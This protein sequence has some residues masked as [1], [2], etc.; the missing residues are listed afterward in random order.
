MSHPANRTVN[1]TAQTSADLLLYPAATGSN[2]PVSMKAGETV[3]SA[4]AT[5]DVAITDPVFVSVTPSGSSVAIPL[6]SSEWYFSGTSL[7]LKRPLAYNATVAWGSAAVHPT[8]TVP[9]GCNGV[10]IQNV[11]ATSVYIR[12]G[13]INAFGL[14]IGKPGDTNSDDVQGI[15]LAA[16]AS[17]F[18]QSG[19]FA[20]GDGWYVLGS[21]GSESVIVNFS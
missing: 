19:Q 17:F 5:S 16:G 15:A 21:A 3:I 14:P 10:T 12:R 9:N 11:A 13:L 20:A 2:S 4:L 1:I 6:P 8:F 18:L 7:K